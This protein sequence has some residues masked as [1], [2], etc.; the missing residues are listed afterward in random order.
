MIKK[1]QVFFEILLK[2][3]FQGCFDIRGHKFADITAQCGNL[4]HKAGRHKLPLIRRHQKHRFNI[5]IKTRI[6]PRHLE[7]VIKI[8]YGAQAAKNAGRIHFFGKVNQKIIKG[9][10]LNLAEFLLHIRQITF[11]HC[12]ALFMCKKRLFAIIRCHSD[13]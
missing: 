12:N 9:Y 6:H 11:D 3:L 8:R 5:G 7:F 4:F 1:G 2:F 10:N 13:I